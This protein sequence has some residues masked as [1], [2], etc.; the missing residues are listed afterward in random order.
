ML[1]YLFWFTVL[2][3]FR[4][5]IGLCTIQLY[6]NSKLGL[7]WPPVNMDSRLKSEMA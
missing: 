3:R 1:C 2:K 7:I 6:T 5:S 4:I